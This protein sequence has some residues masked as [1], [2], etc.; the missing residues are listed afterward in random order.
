VT[1]FVL[2]PVVTPPTPTGNDTIFDVLF[3]VALGGRKHSSFRYY[4]LASDLLDHETVTD[5][6]TVTVR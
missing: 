5:T 2:P 3:P 1:C 6:V 4:A